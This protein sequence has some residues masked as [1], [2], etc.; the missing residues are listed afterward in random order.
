VARLHQESTDPF[1][2]VAAL[3]PVEGK[4]VRSQKE[5]PALPDGLGG[6]LVCLFQEPLGKLEIEKDGRARC[7]ETCGAP[8]GLRAGGA[9]RDKGHAERWKLKVATPDGSPF[10][11]LSLRRST[12][13][14]QELSRG[15]N[16]FDVAAN[17]QRG[18]ALRGCCYPLPISAG[19]VQ[20]APPAN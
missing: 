8:A 1:D 11:A 13:C 12:R 9:R 19:T 6:K 2:D 14:I 10:L 7:S 18:S 3:N 16:V 5:S 4:P 15:P 17:R 20:A